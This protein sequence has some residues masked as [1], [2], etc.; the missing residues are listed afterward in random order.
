MLRIITN[1][2]EH[3]PLW[4]GGITDC[5]ICRR[6]GGSVVKPQFS[7]QH[8]SRPAHSHLCILSSKGSDTHSLILRGP[9]VMRTEPL[10]QLNIYKYNQENTSFL[11]PSQN[12]R[13]RYHQHEMGFDRCR[14][15]PREGPSIQSRNSLSSV[16]HLT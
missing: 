16:S 5:H 12:L 3:Q 4:R 11:R 1:L 10:S 6:R 14:T 13:V 8:P 9:A 2:R 15:E 7:S